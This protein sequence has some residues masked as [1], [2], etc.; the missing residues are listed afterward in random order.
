MLFTI[1]TR[2]RPARL[3]MQ[4]QPRSSIGQNEHATLQNRDVTMQSINTPLSEQVNSRQNRRRT[5]PLVFQS[6]KP[7][8]VSRTKQ[9]V[10]NILVEKYKK[11]TTPQQVIFP[12][13]PSK[14]NN[15]TLEKMPI[16]T[17]GNQTYVINTIPEPEPEP[18]KKFVPSWEREDKEII[19][20]KN[21]Q[22]HKKE[23][24]KE[25]IIHDIVVNNAPAPIVP[26]K[27]SWER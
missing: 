3:S 2:R 17:A 21:I 11:P 7:K 18:E 15:M 19:V 23:I 25:T 24:E 13:F 1:P 14:N 10:A 4:Y 20:E 16:L 22:F 8:S 9:R 6:Y 27:P 12:L 26:P 5:M